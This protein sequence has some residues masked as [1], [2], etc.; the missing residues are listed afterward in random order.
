[1][2]GENSSL[3]F[4][5]CD[6]GIMSSTTR[7][8]RNALIVVAVIIVVVIA[9]F[10]GRASVTSTLPEASEG[11]GS[12]DSATTTAEQPQTAST[13][14]SPTVTD[15][16]A[17]ELLKSAPRRQANDPR[18]IGKVDAPVVMVAYEDFSCPMC[19][20]Y[21]KSVHPQ[22]LDLVE[23]GILRIEFHDF[24]IFPNYGSNIAARG[25]HAAAEQGRFWEFVTQAYGEAGDG[26][27][28]SY[29][30]ES[31]IDIAQRAGVADL[32]AFRTTMNAK[33][34]I[35]AVSAESAKAGHDMGIGG[36]P[37]FVINNTFI[38]GAYPVEYMR[39]TIENQAKEAGVR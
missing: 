34:T 7:I 27:H 4:L 31:V 28:P 5:L 2:H 26:D 18:A 15:T 24:V 22:L 9:F 8:A 11:A 25:S 21:F 10:M 30:E 19:T 37:F 20:R 6:A 16:Q 3:S 13:E 35:D 12:S 32:D 38:S 17:L 23:D 33:E 14:F 29:T 36:T 39:A 1:M